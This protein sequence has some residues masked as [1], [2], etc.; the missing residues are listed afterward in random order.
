MS[1]VSCVL[2][3][4]GSIGSAVQAARLLSSD[5]ID[6]HVGCVSFPSL[7]L[8]RSR[9]VADAVDLDSEG[10]EQF[11]ASLLDWLNSRSLT[12]AV[13]PIIPLSDRLADWLD[14]T[15][16]AFPDHLRLGIPAT[17]ILRPLLA[18]HTA[19]PLAEHAGL[20]VLPWAYVQDENDLDKALPRLAFPLIARPTSWDSVGSSYFKQAVL[21][22]PHEAAAFVQKR[23]AT[24]AEMVIQNYLDVPP[25]A[26]E[27]A[28]L[29]VSLDGELR[30]VVT[31]RKGGTSSP[32]GGVLTWGQTAVLPDVVDAA[33]A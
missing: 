5:G 7:L 23:L 26:I 2:L 19:L 30:S 10:A 13:V 3:A 25:D 9:A 32:G 1:S 15:R 20:D 21:G 18:K 16:A 28:L 22:S 12:H 6:V 17:A 8:R 31:G 24:G 14:R 29:G 4:D 11:T 33:R 27:F